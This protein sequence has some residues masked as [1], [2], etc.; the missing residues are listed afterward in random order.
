VVILFLHEE[1]KEDGSRLVDEEGK[2]VRLPPLK[3]NEPLDLLG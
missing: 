1:A 2:G 3:V